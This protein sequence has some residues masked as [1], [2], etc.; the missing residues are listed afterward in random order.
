MT[1]G[2]SL[3]HRRSFRVAAKD[4]NHAPRCLNSKPPAVVL[5]GLALAVTLWGAGSKFSRYYEAPNAHPRVPVA[6]LWIEHRFGFADLLSI[7]TAPTV[8]ERIF[9]QSGA[10]AFIAHPAELYLRAVAGA[11]PVAAQPRPI[12]FF[13]SPI[14]LRSPPSLLSF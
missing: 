6:R 9:A 7:A 8:K 10:G 13:H 5:L 4:R 11:L 12:P 1:V 14:P 3:A 2:N